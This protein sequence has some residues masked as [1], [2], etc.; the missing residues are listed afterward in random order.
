M[1]KYKA[2]PG[3]ILP[4]KY[5]GKI[6]HITEEG[7]E[8]DE[9]KLDYVTKCHLARAIKDGDIVEAGE[10][11]PKKARKNDKGDK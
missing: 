4:I 10:E 9:S 7:I 8:L 5:Q 11:A 2:N 6:V 3:K 1:K